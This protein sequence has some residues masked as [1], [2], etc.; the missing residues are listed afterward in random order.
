[1]IFCIKESIRKQHEYAQDRRPWRTK[2]VATDEKTL[3]TMNRIFVVEIIW[4]QTL[5]CG[6]QGS[7]KKKISCDKI[8]QTDTSGSEPQMWLASFTCWFTS[9]DPVWVCNA[10]YC[11]DICCQEQAPWNDREF[12]HIAGWWSGVWRG[13][14]GIN[15]VVVVQVWPPECWETQGGLL[16]V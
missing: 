15:V 4:W 9:V 1:M 12:I 10:G 2:D 7:G 13:G 11:K 3:H 8:T 14:G 16:S 6:V 5:L